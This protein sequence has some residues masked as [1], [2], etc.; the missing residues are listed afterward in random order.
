MSREIPSVRARL[1]SAALTT[2]DRLIWNWLCELQFSRYQRRGRFAAAME[3][4]H[5]DA[6]LMWWA[7]TT[8]LGFMIV[9]PEPGGMVAVRLSR[10]LGVAVRLG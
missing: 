1:P 2:E 9:N 3:A 7:Q 8:E 5:R 10:Q 4:E 6:S